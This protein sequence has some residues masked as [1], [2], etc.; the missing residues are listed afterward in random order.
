MYVYQYTEAFCHYPLNFTYYLE[1][2]NRKI[3]KIEKLREKKVEIM[4]QKLS[5]ENGP[6]CRQE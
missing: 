4:E 2:K 6:W 5:D 3:Y 1:K